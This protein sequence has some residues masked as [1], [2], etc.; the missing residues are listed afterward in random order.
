MIVDLGRPGER[1]LV[2]GVTGFSQVE[3]EA[4]VCQDAG[5]RLSRPR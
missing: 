1:C 3:N 5:R 4:I 2:A